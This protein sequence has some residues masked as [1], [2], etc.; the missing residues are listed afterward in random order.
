MNIVSNNQV[1]QSNDWSRFF[2]IEVWSRTQVAIKRLM[3]R[4][5]VTRRAFFR[6]VSHF[7]SLSTRRS[8]RGWSSDLLC[9]RFRHV[10]RNSR[11]ITILTGEGFKRGWR[12]EGAFLKEIVEGKWELFEEVE[13]RVVKKHDG[14][15]NA[16]LIDRCH[17]RKRTRRAVDTKSSHLRITRTHRHYAMRSA[18]SRYQ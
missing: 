10:T 12:L 5:F 9:R 17:P 11:R 1:D 7:S 3:F 6:I 14:L 13:P 2:F 4:F 18:S 8:N 15:M 16:R